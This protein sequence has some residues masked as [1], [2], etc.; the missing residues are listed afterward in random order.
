MIP[1]VCR[2]G[3]STGLPFSVT[4]EML[5]AASVVATVMKIVASATR[6]PGQILNTS[7]SR[8]Y[9]KGMHEGAYR[10]P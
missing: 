10:L 6:I 7:T 9:C 2:N 3:G 5:N 1:D 4:G 8:V